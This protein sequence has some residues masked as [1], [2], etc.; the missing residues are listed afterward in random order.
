ME[1]MIADMLKKQEAKF[2]AFFQ[3]QAESLKI[4][5]VQ[6]RQ[7]TYN[8]QSF[9]PQEILPL[10]SDIEEDMWNQENC[11]DTIMGKEAEPY[12]ETEMS[13][14]EPEQTE[15]RIDLETLPFIE[16]IHEDVV[17]QGVRQEQLCEHI[18]NLMRQMDTSQHG[19]ASI[20]D[21][22][23][24]LDRMTQPF[25][26]KHPIRPPD[27]PFFYSRLPKYKSLKKVVGAQ[28][29][30]NLY[31]PSHVWKRRLN[32]NAHGTILSRTSKATLKPP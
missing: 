20:I 15:P 31:L 7:L 29:S 4:M 5:E 21:T 32:S 24:E 22:A 13:I 23:Y 8:A 11:N 30:E 16:C 10:S 28:S 2:D 12:I 9:I 3:S 6:I 1:E 14:Q 17:D 25:Q 19:E 18:E 27:G 26:V